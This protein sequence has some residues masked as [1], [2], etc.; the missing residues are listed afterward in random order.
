MRTLPLAGLV[1]GLVG[2]ASLPAFAALSSADRNFVE[3]A[4]S[5]GMAEVQTAQLAQER[6]GSPEVKQFANRMITDHTQAN[7]E[8]SRLRSS[9]TSPCR[10]S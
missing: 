6:S 3:Q 4:A 2:V 8:R 1:A 10:P 5:G 9:K 7:T